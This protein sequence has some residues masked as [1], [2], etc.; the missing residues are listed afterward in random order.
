MEQ[1][2][3]YIALNR[4]IHELKKQI[5]D[6]KKRLEPLEHIVMDYMS[7]EDLDFM[8]LDS[9]ELTRYD[10]KTPKKTSKEELLSKLSKEL[11][12][13]KAKIEKIMQNTNEENAIVQPKLKIKFYD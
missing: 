2:K 7:S 11:N 5:K 3:H 9:A 4:E 6:V 1:L 12:Q 8:T 10:K 13:D